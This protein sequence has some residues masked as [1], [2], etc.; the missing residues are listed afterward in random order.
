MTPV[1]FPDEE[2]EIPPNSLSLKNITNTT[3][4]N[5]FTSKIIER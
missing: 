3:H 5:T 4:A 2:Y 1:S